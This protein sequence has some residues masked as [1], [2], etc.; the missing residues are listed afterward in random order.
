[1][2]LKVTLFCQ[3]ILDLGL[4]LK[5]VTDG[6]LTKVI[7]FDGKAEVEEHIRSIGIPATF[8]LM[9]AFMPFTLQML[10]PI[11]SSGPQKSYK[12]SLLAPSETKWPLISVN[13]D[14][15]KIVKAILLNREKV[16]G[17]QFY[18]AVKEYKLGEI[19]QILK[20]RGGL[21]VT[22][23]QISEAEFMKE[24]EAKGFPEFFRNTMIETMRFGTKYDFLAGVEYYA[25]HQVRATVFCSIEPGRRIC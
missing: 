24:M 11:A 19:V 20:E 6:E 23:E 9:G 7:H 14:T 17:K 12:L 15:G 1:M 3:I 4:T 18:G 21:D 2:F 5:L 10:A 16:L 13:E 25:N 8:I 22:Y